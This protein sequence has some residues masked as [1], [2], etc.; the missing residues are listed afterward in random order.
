MEKKQYRELGELTNIG[1]GEDIKMR[2]FVEIVENIVGYKG[3]VKYDCFR[4]DGT[5]RK[6]LDISKIKNLGWYP[7]VGLEDGIRRAYKW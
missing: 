1:T 5:L 2:E 3:E 6:L 7:K 4:P